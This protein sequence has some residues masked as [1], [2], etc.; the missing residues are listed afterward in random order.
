MPVI[1]AHA[2]GE[3]LLCQI[4]TNCRSIHSDFPL[5]ALQIELREFNLATSMP[6]DSYRLRD[7]G[8]PLI[9]VS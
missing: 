6:V 5:S 2:D 3:Y 4:H 8:S 7:V 9:V 1:V